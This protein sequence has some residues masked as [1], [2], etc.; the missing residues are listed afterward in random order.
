MA[1]S[2]SKTFIAKLS[3]NAVRAMYN[4]KTPNRIYSY[5]TDLACTVSD[6]LLGFLNNAYCSPGKASF[7]KLEGNHLQV[8][9]S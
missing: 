2:S 6:A 1:T 8:D 5:I 3:S 4:I 9:E 7:Q